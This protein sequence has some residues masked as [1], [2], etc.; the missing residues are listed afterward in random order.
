MD[1]QDENA[2]ASGGETS[3]D[4]G[5]GT[6]AEQEVVSVPKKELEKLRG[7]YK[8][9]VGRMKTVS[10][11]ESQ[12][13]DLKGQI[14]AN[15]RQMAE[16]QRQVEA[17]EDGK[18]SALPAD[19]QALA[20][21]RRELKAQIAT[22]K[23][24]NDGLKKASGRLQVLERQA[25]AL[26]IEVELGLPPKSLAEYA[27]LPEDRLRA[28]GERLKGAKAPETETKGQTGDSLAGRGAKT[29]SDDDF[30]KA[31][32]AGDSDDHKRARAIQQAR[33]IKV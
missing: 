30:L 18:I 14:E 8:S 20:K 16:L 10:Q 33:G 5:G 19:A 28:L 26:E 29:L 13:A 15:A 11:I 21:E 32:A 17:A 31:Y 3:Q 6:S 23:T 25:K 12:N 24:E 1:K 27:D 2:T 7:D 9:M 22:L 4:Q